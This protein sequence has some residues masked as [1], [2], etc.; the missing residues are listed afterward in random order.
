MR[1]PPR[2]SWRRPGKRSAPTE[3]PGSPRRR[4]R[5]HA[6]RRQPQHRRIQRRLRPL[7]RRHAR[8]RRHLL[9]PHRRARTPAPAGGCAPC[10]R[11]PPPPP[12]AAPSSDSASATPG[13]CTFAPRYR[14]RLLRR[15]PRPPRRSSRSTYSA[16]AATA[17]W[18]Q[19]A[20]SACH[21]TGSAWPPTAAP[22]PGGSTTAP[23][24][25]PGAPTTPPSAGAPTTTP[26]TPPGR[27]VLRR[28]PR[29]ERWHSRRSG[30]NAA[31][32]CTHGSWRRSACGTNRRAGC[33]ERCPTGR[34]GPK[35]A[36]YRRAGLPPRTSGHRAASRGP[37]A[38]R[39][40]QTPIA[41]G[42]ATVTGPRRLDDFRG[43]RRESPGGRPHRH[44]RARPDHHS[45]SRRT[46]IC[47]SQRAGSLPLRCA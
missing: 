34:P 10:G 26:T 31:G 18:R 45:R 28:L 36:A 42:C 12:A 46:A 21:H 33:A 39:R 4:R 22:P 41:P 32:G 47:P 17:V 44:H 14:R 16:S 43:Q 37:A 5:L 9:R 8:H 19:A 6:L 20:A 25:R 40:A 3:N 11:T 27:P 29:P 30:R 2:S 15:Q 24:P 35:R 7:L 38:G 1:K 13:G 23:P